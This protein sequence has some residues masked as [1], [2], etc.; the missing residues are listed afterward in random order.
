MARDTHRESQGLLASLAALA[1]T[2]V[3]ITHT[4][5]ELLSIDLEEAR[6]HVFSQIVLTLAALFFLSVGIV[7][8][9]ILLVVV[10]WDTH[11]L[12]VLGGLAGF[13][14]A[15]GIGI[16]AFVLHKVRTRPRLFVA[17]LSELFKDQQH[18]SSRQ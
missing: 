14:L 3:A 15:L 1:S 2:L 6:E 4:R 18:L 8:A 11:R 16:W 17:S 9:A 12:L 7:L 13:F 5:L 10:F